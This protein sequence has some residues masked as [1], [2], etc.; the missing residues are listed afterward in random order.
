MGYHEC[1]GRAVWVDEGEYATCAACGHTFG[2]G[3]MEE[4]EDDDGNL[5]DVC[6][7]SIACRKRDPAGHEA[8]FFGPQRTWNNYINENC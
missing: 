2:S 4:I 1:H 6:S 8:F 5:Y 3:S 7:D